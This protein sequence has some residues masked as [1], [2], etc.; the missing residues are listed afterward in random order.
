[1]EDEKKKEL[2][3]KEELLKDL[4]EKL[5]KMPAKELV[6]VMATDLASM[7]FRKLGMHDEKQKDLA[8]AKLAIDSF[9]ALFGVLKDQIEEKE[10]Q[11][12]ESA[13]ANLKMAYVKEKE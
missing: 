2:L 12:L 7:A 8:Q 10:K 6:S 11:V 13:Q 9:E 3:D 1:M 5:E 4:N